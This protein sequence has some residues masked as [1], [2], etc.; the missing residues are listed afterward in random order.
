MAVSR[1]QSGVKFLAG[2]RAAH[3]GE[4]LRSALPEDIHADTL[5]QYAT[6]LGYDVTSESIEDAFRLRMQ[7]REMARRRHLKSPVQSPSSP[8]QPPPR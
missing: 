5:A 7:V 2:L 3:E 4:A 8:A 1:L 6:G